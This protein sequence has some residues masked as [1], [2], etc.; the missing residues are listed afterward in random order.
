MKCTCNKLHDGW[1]VS[2]AQKCEML[3]QKGQKK[4]WLEEQMFCTLGEMG[5]L[6][7]K[8]LSTISSFPQEHSYKQ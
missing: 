3:L 4:F 8:I 5:D 1:S 7:L 2:S 6:C